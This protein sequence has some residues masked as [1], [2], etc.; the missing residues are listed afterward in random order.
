[1][2]KADAGGDGYV[3]PATV[4]GGGDRPS[5]SVK[6][7]PQTSD[8]YTLPSGNDKGER[9]AKAKGG[10]TSNDGYDNMGI[11]TDGPGNMGKSGSK[12]PGSIK[13]TGKKVDPQWQG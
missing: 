7:N 3:N 10:S 11:N 12:Y 1:M 9:E 8:G 6:Q 4:N 5:P 2:P 13:S